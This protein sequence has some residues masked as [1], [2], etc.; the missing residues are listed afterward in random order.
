MHVREG[1]KTNLRRESVIAL[2]VLSLAALFCLAACGN[3]GTSGSVVRKTRFLLVSDNANNRVLIY[4]VPLNSGQSANLVLGQASFTASTASLSASGMNLPVATTQDSADN[5]YVSD[6]NNNRVLQ[7][8][9]PLSNGMSAT[10]TFGQPNLVSGD[11]NTTQNGLRR[12]GGLAFD[13]SGNLWVVDFGNNRLLQFKPPFSNGMNASLVIGQGN[14]I[15]GAPATTNSA[16]RGPHL[17]AFDASGNLWVT[18]SGNDRVLEFK[19]P[20]ANGM[21]A[22]VVIGQTDFISSASATTASG[23]AFPTGIAFEGSGN[24]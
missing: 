14:F 9:A 12:P 8:K 24:L 11:A 4:N 13:S 22:S 2:G 15:S 17:I 23:L 3:G 1:H 18:D 7:F 21:A 5:I 6:L 19:P 20:F 10:L 16:L